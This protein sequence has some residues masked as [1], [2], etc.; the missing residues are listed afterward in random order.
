MYWKKDKNLVGFGE[1][2]N[3]VWAMPNKNTFSIKPIGEL[4]SRHLSGFS[5]DPFANSNRLAVCTNDLDPDHDTDFNMDALDFLKMF[6]VAAYI[7]FGWDMESGASFNWDVD[8]R[9]EYEQDRSS[10]QDRNDIFRY[11]RSFSD[12]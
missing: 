8:A 10:C 3:R 6:P 4:I 5:I 9:V 1:M 7:G 2:I 11:Q 12:G